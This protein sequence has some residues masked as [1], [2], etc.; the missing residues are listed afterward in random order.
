MNLF[1]FILNL[2]LI[3]HVTARHIKVVK[4]QVKQVK[5]VKQFPIKIIPNIEITC[6]GWIV[7][8]R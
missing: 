3:I 1:K 8:Q 6:N 5:Q 7:K 2:I 4:Q